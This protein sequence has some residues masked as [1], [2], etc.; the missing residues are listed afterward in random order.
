MN[1]LLTYEFK[2]HEIWDAGVAQ[3]VKCPTVGFG[4]AHDFAVG[5]FQPLHW[6][7]C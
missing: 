6:A 4:A 1:G 3:A 5:Q 2:N 7:V